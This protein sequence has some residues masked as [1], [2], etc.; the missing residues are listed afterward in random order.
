MKIY[1]DTFISI[2]WSVPAVLLQQEEKKGKEETVKEKDRKR[3]REKY[4]EMVSVQSHTFFIKTRL[5][6]FTTRVDRINTVVILHWT[7]V[8]VF[9]I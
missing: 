8:V 1:N 5:H 3:K 2:P 9:T 4:A 7:Q 6:M